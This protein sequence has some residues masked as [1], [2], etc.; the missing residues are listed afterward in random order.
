MSNVDWSSRTKIRSAITSADVSNPSISGS[1]LVSKLGS[2]YAIVEIEVDGSGSPS[3]TATPL[4]G[5]NS[6][7]YAGT[8]QPDIATNSVFLV[9][10]ANYDKFTVK[11]TSFSGSPSINVYVTPYKK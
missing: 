4:F 8:A 7:W 11:L 9:E 10:L 5:S 6:E 2:N 3:C 1:E